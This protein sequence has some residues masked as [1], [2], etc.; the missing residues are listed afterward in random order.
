MQ[1]AFLIL[2]LFQQVSQGVVGICMLVKIIAA[3]RR[4]LCVMGE[5]RVAMDLMSMGGQRGQKGVLS[6]FTL[7]M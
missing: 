2:I 3:F 4:M 6:Y 5:T 1:S 7:L